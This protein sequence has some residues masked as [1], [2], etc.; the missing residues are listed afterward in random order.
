MSCLNAI[1]AKSCP[2]RG[3]L[4]AQSAAAFRQAVARTVLQ[5]VEASP[6]PSLSKLPEAWS[7]QLLSPTTPTLNDAVK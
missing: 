2:Q 5:S 3:S 7:H 1:L 6:S 4:Q